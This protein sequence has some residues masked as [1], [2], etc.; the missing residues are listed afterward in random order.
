[1]RP[2]LL[3]WQR[4]GYPQFH[5]HKGNLLLHIVAVP[6]FIG[7]TLAT[8]GTLVSGHGV[9]ALIS[10]VLMA[11][12]FGVQGAGHGREATRSIPFDGPSD[13]ITRIFAEQFVTFP[14]FVL[15]GGWWRA[16]TLAGQG[17]DGSE[18]S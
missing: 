12:A 13:A 7:A 8:V 11:I 16:L 5:R 17:R 9:G 1:M 6:T 3:E 14:W 10:M 2:R 15:S 4:E 18:R